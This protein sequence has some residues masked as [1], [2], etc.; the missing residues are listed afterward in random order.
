MYAIL[1]LVAGLIFLA[2]AATF[3]EKFPLLAIATGIGIV[4]CPWIF[5]GNL[6]KM[7]GLA[8]LILFTPY[9]ACLG[10]GA[11]LI[12]LGKAGLSG[13]ADAEFKEILDKTKL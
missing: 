12:K 5:I 3:A 11:A 6:F 13:D 8:I 2:L 1:I 7:D 9:L 4:V 10:A